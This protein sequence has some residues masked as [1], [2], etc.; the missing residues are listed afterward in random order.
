MA[1][2]AGR[3]GR[4][5]KFTPE[6]V[7]KILKLIADG[8]SERDIFRQE[9]MPSWSCWCE[10]KRAQYDPEKYPNSIFP[11]L[12]TSAKSDGYKQW[13]SEIRRIARD[14]SRDYYV[15]EKGYRCYNTTAALRDRLII[16][17]DKWLMAK[18]MPKVYGESI[19]QELSGPNDGPIPVIAISMHDT[20]KE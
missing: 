13:E 7:D 14:D 2:K 5:S 4:P 17:S 15:N 8:S 12:Y 6:L 11:D 10:F 9:D 1:G 18:G 3:S 20:K 16:D 19:K